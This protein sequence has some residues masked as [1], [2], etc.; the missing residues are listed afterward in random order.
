MEKRILLISNNVYHYRIP[1]Y[2]YFY[3]EFA[4]NNIEFS[5]LT[6]DIQKE[7]PNPIDFKYAVIKPSVKRYKAH[8]DKVNPDVVIFFMHLKD[9]IMWPL[10]PYLKRKNVAIIKWGHGVNL[11]D[12][13]NPI[14]NFLFQRIYKACSAI[15]L[16]SPEQ[17]K[18][19]DE[20]FHHKIFIAYNTINLNSF[21][22]IEKSKQEIKKE[23]GIPFET[24]ILFVG[25]IRKYKKL[26][27]LLDIFQNFSVSNAGL[28]IAGPGMNEEQLNIVNAS[29]KI[30]YLGP[31]YD[32]YK[33]NSVF[34]MADIFCIP[35]TN[36]LGLN[37]AMYWGLP[38]ITMEGKHAPEIIYL[39]DGFNGY[40]TPNDSILF[41]KEKLELVA[42]DKEL[43]AELSSNAKETMQKEG[44]IS[45][46]FAGFMKTINYVLNKNARK[47]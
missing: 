13:S 23:L 38:V 4:K 12:P 2:N 10:L 27:I 8:I 33:I 32:E 46:M 15:I 25:R 16:Y 5:L 45:N 47:S 9:W 29:D 7:N 11:Q 42:K 20:Q 35:G 40:I 34:K 43:M 18:Y 6:Y 24:V 41:L 30:I 39:K 36:G 19:I 3:K 28:V 37:Q 21:P 1:V 44:N 26:D 31:I 17:K 22:K 14:K